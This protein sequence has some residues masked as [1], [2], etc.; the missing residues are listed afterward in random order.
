[1]EDAEENKKHRS[2]FEGAEQAEIPLVQ[3]EAR[4]PGV[5]VIFGVQPRGDEHGPKR[6]CPKYPLQEDKNST[7]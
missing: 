6:T 3:R 1:M 7:R 2:R 5:G 4:K